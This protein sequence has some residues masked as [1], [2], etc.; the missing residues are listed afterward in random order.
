M[1]YGGDNPKII[2]EGTVISVEVKR[3]KDLTWGEITSVMKVVC[4]CEDNEE[5]RCGFG[6]DFHFRYWLN[7]I[8]GEGTYESNPYVFIIGVEYD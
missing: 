2:K 4:N 3:A 8:H 6:H 7:S 5:N 1:D